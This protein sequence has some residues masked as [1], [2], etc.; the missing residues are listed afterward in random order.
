MKAI[1]F[2]VWALV[3]YWTLRSISNDIKLLINDRKSEEQAAE[4]SH[5]P[6]TEN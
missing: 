3:I 6:E 4:T 2:V 5:E 1:F